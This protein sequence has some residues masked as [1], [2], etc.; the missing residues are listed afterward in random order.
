ML[1]AHS[2]GHFGELAGDYRN[3]IMILHCLLGITPPVF[4]IT[5]WLKMPISYMRVEIC[6]S[7]Q[8]YFV[9]TGAVTVQKRIIHYTKV[10]IFLDIFVQLREMANFAWDR[11]SLLNLDHYHFLLKW[12][13]Y[14]YDLSQMYVMNLHKCL[15]CN[16][17][18]IN[19]RN[20]C[21]IFQYI[22]SQKTKSKLFLDK[23]YVS[24]FRPTTIG[25]TH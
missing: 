4:I 11:S 14:G 23:I 19:D 25:Y 17:I 22:G 15:L 9:K 6:Y 20:V 7:S 13:K 1:N 8:R 18:E 10:K 24:P 12:C 3:V 2:I 5:D 21:L 16:E